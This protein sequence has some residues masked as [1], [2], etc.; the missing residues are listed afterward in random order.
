MIREL[1]KA[2]INIVAD[3]WLD[4]NIKAHYKGP[5]FYLCSI[6]EKKFGACERTAVAGNRLC[7]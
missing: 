5:L 2:D 3:I 7:L 4:T 1:R 6:L